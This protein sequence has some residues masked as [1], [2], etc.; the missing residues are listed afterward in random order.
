M[1]AA[2]VI[3][4]DGNVV[5]V[6]LDDN[7]VGQIGKFLDCPRV[8]CVALTSRLDM[9]IDDDGFEVLPANPV[10][11]ALARRFGFVWQDYYGPVLLCSVDADRNSVDLDRDQV[12][13]V[14]T[15]L[16]DV[17]DGSR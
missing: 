9:W 8:D 2:L 16:L 14:L 7:E 1:G 13:G 3:H 10:A 17:T 12:V 5:E 4:P 6:D 11:T 15:H